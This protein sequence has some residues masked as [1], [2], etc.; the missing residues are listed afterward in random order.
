[1]ARDGDDRL[2]SVSF[3]AAQADFSEA[4]ELKLFLDESQVSFLE[5]M[6]QRRGYL[7]SRQMTGAFQLL[8]S[9]DLIWSR[10]IRDY[11]LGDR[12]GN[13]DIL[14]WNADA[15][16][17]PARMHS[18]Y[19]RRLFLE[20]DLAEGRFAVAG[21]PVALSDLRVPLFVVGTELDHVAPWRSVYKFNLL[22]DADV[23]F[24]LT[25]G[26]HNGGILSVPGNADRHFRVASKAADA[27]YTDPN[28]WLA[29]TPAQAGSWW[30]IWTNWLTD[31]AGPL[32]EPPP[33]GR[34]D[35]GYAP[36]CDAPGTFVLMT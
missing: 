17:M 6:M 5:D 2:E 3:L 27:R 18:D 10:V 26:G 25:S 31:R 15:T 19:L 14:A 8:R 24:L 30:P 32:G 13:F 35:A 34:A 1:M 23:T 29:D 22:T 16:R 21:A 28:R 11:L 4:G 7:D 33:L 20:N 9:N 12:S 36:L